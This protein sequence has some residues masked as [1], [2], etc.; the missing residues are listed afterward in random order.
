MMS[1]RISL[2]YNYRP[3]SVSALRTRAAIFGH[4]APLWTALPTIQRIGEF[5]TVPDPNNPRSRISQFVAGPYSTR[6]YSWA[7]KTLAN[8][9]G[10]SSNDRHMYLDNGYPTLV[11]G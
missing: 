10:A 1:L 5:V 4:N 11:Q 2:P 3:P 8:Y 7:E 9:P 6:Q